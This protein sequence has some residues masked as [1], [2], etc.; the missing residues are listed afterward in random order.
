L[1]KRVFT[2]MLADGLSIDSE[3]AEIDRWAERFSAR[4]AEG[5]R[6]VLGELMD[7]DPGYATGAVVVHQGQVAVL[8]PG[9]PADKSLIWPDAVERDCG[10]ND[11]TS[12]P[13]PPSESES[14][15]ERADAVAGSELLRQFSRLADWV[16][17]EGRPV[18]RRGEP[19]PKDLQAATAAL[20]LTDTRAKRLDDVPAFALLWALA[21]E[22]G[23]LAV[24]R[25]SVFPGGAAAEVDAALR[26]E[27]SPERAVALWD[28][29]FDELVHPSGAATSPEREALREWAQP[30]LPRM[31]G[32]LYTEYAGDGF[33][34]VERL[35][36]DTIPDVHGEVPAGRYELLTALG[37]TAMKH[38]LFRLAEHAAVEVDVPSLPEAPPAKAATAART[39]GMP[40]WV[41]HGSPGARVR[42]TDLGRR[43]VHRRLTGEREERVPATT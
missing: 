13:P 28:E 32:K 22:L 2:A 24:R 34:D 37:A 1:A 35:V 25:T 26:R 20:D 39:M 3:P 41:V 42:L 16:G 19:N 7:S 33:V 12:L 6:R 38:G 9:M 14:E 4:D 40:L 18:D 10:C 36:E 15:L 30:L 31:L 11:V 43:A 21:V 27:G 5:R 8:L 23:V 29:V 17:T